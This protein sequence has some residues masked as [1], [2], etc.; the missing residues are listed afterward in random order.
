MVGLPEKLAKT[1]V[2]LCA[3]ESSSPDISPIPGLAW[4]WKH[5]DLGKHQT[6][7]EQKSAP[8]TRT[9]E[10]LGTDIFVVGCALFIHLLFPSLPYTPDIGPKSWYTMQGILFEHNNEIV[11]V[12]GLEGLQDKKA[13]DNW[14]ES[15]SRRAASCPAT[16]TK[17]SA[18]SDP[19]TGMGGLEGSA[20]TASSFPTS[21]TVSNQQSNLLNSTS[22]LKR[23]S[24]AK[25][26]LKDVFFCV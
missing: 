15:G 17:I 18:T 4:S 7:L 2:C 11:F 3:V 24:A 26:I 22:K 8:L 12:Q 13:H 21:Q 19:A 1:I 10:P 25:M 23:K 5:L 14:A 16:T 6:P 20:P 9:S